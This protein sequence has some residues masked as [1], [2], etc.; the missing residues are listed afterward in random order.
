MQ[1]RW[2]EITGFEAKMPHEFEIIILQLV[3]MGGELFFL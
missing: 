1:G 2:S 3:D